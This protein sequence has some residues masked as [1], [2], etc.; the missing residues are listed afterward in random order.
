MWATVFIFANALSIAF[1]FVP[2]T[3]ESIMRNAFLSGF[4]AYF[5]AFTTAVLNTSVILV[6]TVESWSITAWLIFWP[7][8]SMAVNFMWATTENIGLWLTVMFEVRAA[9]IVFIL[10]AASCFI[11]ISLE[12]FI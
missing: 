5:A 6:F 8:F 2:F 12:D 3:T 9:H 11:V 7:A 4:T 1:N 10:A